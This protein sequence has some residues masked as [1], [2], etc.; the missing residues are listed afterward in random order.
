MQ[1]NGAPRGHEKQ[2]HLSSL[3]CPEKDNDV[4][5]NRLLHN[6][7][8]NCRLT[9]EQYIFS[10]FLI[11]DKIKQYYYKNK[12]VFPH[13]TA[14]HNAWYYIIPV[15]TTFVFC[16]LAQ[17]SLQGESV[18]LESSS[19]LHIPALSARRPALCSSVCSCSLR[20]L[21][22]C[23]LDSL[24]VQLFILFCKKNVWPAV[25]YCGFTKANFN[26]KAD[27]RWL[28]ER[29]GGVTCTSVQLCSVFLCYPVVRSVHTY[30]HLEPV[31][32]A[33]LLHR[34]MFCF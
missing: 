34:R 23:S 12:S 27:E 30:A 3:T 21:V 19:W 33:A 29:T 2:P 8:L 16:Q 25:R 18:Y 11:L 5:I 28:G 7:W 10:V 6:T 13:K 31:A 15:A 32:P 26:K 17:I 9:L 4:N 24:R 1:L 20:A 22:G 14:F